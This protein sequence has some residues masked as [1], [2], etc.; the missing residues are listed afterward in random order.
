MAVLSTHAERKRNVGIR[1]LRHEALS[2][3]KLVSGYLS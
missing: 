2:D 1:V 3:K